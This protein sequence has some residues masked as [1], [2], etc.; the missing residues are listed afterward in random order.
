[1]KRLITTSITSFLVA[2]L[3]GACVP[4]PVPTRTASGWQTFSNAEAGF[5]IM[6][7]PTWSRQTLPD[8]NGGAIHGEAFTGSEGGVEVYWG[9]GF[10]GACPTGTVPVRVAAGE[11]PACHA[12]KSDGTEVWSQIGYEVS[13][14]NSFSVRAYTGDAQPSSHDLVLEVLSTLTFMPPAPAQA[15]ATVPAPR[16]GAGAANPASQN[17]ANQGGTLSIEARGDGGQFGVCYFEDNR[18][19]EEWALL[20]GTVPLAASR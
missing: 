11:L 7:P 1:V 6:A 5:S 4:A 14:G 13:G 2:L 8:Q 20:R 19:C 18:Q 3:L 9:V 12:T 16:P 10:G 15:G 17:C